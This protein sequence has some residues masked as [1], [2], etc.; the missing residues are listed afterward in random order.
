DD[1]F[2]DPDAD[3]FPSI[4]EYVNGRT[5]PTV[6]NDNPLPQITVAAGGPTPTLQ[7]AFD[8]LSAD[9]QLIYVSPGIYVGSSNLASSKPK[10]PLIYTNSDPSQTTLTV[11]AT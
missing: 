9:Y 5:N 2:D 6:A 8:Q 4:Y 3:G 7:A 1:A 10:Y 11:N